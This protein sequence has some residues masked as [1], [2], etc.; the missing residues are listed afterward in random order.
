VREAAFA[1]LLRF[2][3]LIA[4]PEAELD[5]AEGALLIADVAY[6]ALAH[7]RYLRQL[8]ELAAAVRAELNPELD[9][10]GKEPHPPA[11]LATR[12]QA[13]RGLAALRA[14]L[15]EREG[16]HGNREHYYDAG[17]S[18]LNRVLE[19]RTGL[20]ITL[21]VVYLEVARRAGLPLCGVGLPAHF[22]VKWPLPEAQGGDIF[23]DPFHG[24]EVLDVAGCWRLVMRMLG[25][26]G[27]PLAFDPQWMCAVGPRAILTRILQNLKLLYL[28]RGET[29][30]ALEVVERLLL[31]RPGSAEDLRDRGLLRLAMGESLLAA[32]DIAAYTARTPNAPDVKRLRRR[33]SGTTDL[34]CKLN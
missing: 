32:A 19:R 31:L 25:R 30:L 10:M 7:W 23:M 1:P 17:N 28:Q 6:P 29:A 11:R 20:P 18:F 16:F 5:L 27:A 21:S 34:R 8:D 3:A 12:E 4:R 22:V 2:S 33:L 15:A 26:S 13:E 9:P 14:V 24:A